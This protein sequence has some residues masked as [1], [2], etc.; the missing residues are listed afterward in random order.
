MEVYVIHEEDRGIIG[1]AKTEEVAKQWLIDSSRVC[2][3]SEIWIPDESDLIPLKELHE[4]WKEWF[5]NEAD[6]EDLEDM[7]FYLG[8]EILIE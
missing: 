1:I 3:D 6:A 8:K 5:I 7:G 2:E 4:N